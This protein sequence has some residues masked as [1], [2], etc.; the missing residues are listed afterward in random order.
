M[1]NQQERERTPSAFAKINHDHYFTYCNRDLSF[2]ERSFF[3]CFF[4]LCALF[5]K[6]TRKRKKAPVFRQGDELRIFLIN[7]LDVFILSIV[8]GIFSIEVIV[9]GKRKIHP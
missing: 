4:L 1:P 2:I 3:A 8:Y 9:F 5:G 6:I 7:L